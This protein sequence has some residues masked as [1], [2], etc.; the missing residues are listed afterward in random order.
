MHGL[1]GVKVLELGNL[2]SAAY[3]TKIMSDLG[4]DVMKL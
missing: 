1:E 3:E 4:A 2:V